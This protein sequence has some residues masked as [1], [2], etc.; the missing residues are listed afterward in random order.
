[1]AHAASMQDAGKSSSPALTLMEAKLKRHLERTE[2]SGLD[3]AVVP[4]VVISVVSWILYNGNSPTYIYIS[5][6]I[7]MYMYI[8]IHM[9]VHTCTQTDRQIDR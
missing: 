2:A 9:Y 6:Y 3:R 1:M 8:D 4:F 7:Y 5:T